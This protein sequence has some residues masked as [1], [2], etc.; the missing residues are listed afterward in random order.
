MGLIEILTI[1][2][3]VLKLVGSIDWTWWWVFSPMW[4][5]YTVILAIYG[6]VYRF[7]KRMSRT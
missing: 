1:V 4:I 6:G 5:G 7:T 3:V 2:F